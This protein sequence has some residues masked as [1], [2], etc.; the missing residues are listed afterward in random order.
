MTQILE[1]LENHPKEVKIILGITDKQLKKL[2]ENAQNLE[3]NRKYAIMRPIA[4]AFQGADW[5]KRS[6][7]KRIN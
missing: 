7:I 3:E 1:Y 4:N 5:L 2:I 6:N